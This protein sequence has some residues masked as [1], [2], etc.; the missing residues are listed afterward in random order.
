[1]SDIAREITPVNIEEELKS[2]YLDYA[3]SVIVGRALPDVRDGLKPVHRRVLF[4]MNVLGNDWNKPY[5]K[6]ARVVGDVIGKYHPHGDIAVYGTIVRLAQPF[7]MRYMLVDGQGNFGSVDGDSAAAMRYTEVRMAK[8]AHELLADLEKE[9]VDFVPNYDGTENIPAVMPTRIPNLLVNGSSG[10][11]VGMATNIPPHNLGEVIDGCL[12]YVDNEDI[13]IEELMEYITGP[14]FP[15]AAIINGRRGI[16]D[17]YR[18]GRGKIYIRAQAD[19]ETDEKTGRETIIVTE[20]PYQVNKARLIEKIA[21]LVKDKRIEGISGLRDESDKDG[22]RIV[23][24]IKRDA[25][26][27]VVLNHL[28]SQTQM[29]VSFGINMVALHQGQPKLLNLKEIIAAFIRHRREV[30]TRRTIFELRKAR[31]RAHI[32]EALAVALANIDPV[33]ELIRQAPTPAEAKAALIAQPWDLGSV[34]AMLERAGDSNVARPEWLEPQFGVHDGKY[35]L[36]EQQAQAILDLRLQK[37]TGL[38]HEK[39]LDEYRE[40]LLQIAELLHILRSPERLMDVIRE[41]LTAI[42]TQYNDPRRTEITENTADINIEDLI[43]EE[44]VVVT[45]SHQGYVKY[46]PL[47][48]YEAQR[49]GGKGKSAARIKEEDFIDR[50]LVANTHDTILCFSSRGRLYWMK[51]YQLPEASRG[52]RGRPII[53]LLPLEQDERITAILPVREYEE[54]KFVFMATASGTVKKTPL[55]DFSRPR[56][57]GIIAVNLNDGDELIG[58]DLT[59]GSNEAMLFSADGKVVRFAEECVRPMGRTA[60]GVRGMKL[61]DDDKVVSLIIPRG[62][63]DILTVTENGYGKRTVQSEYPTKN[64]ATQGVISIKVSERNGKVVGAIQVEETDQI[65]MITNA[66]TLVRTRVSEVSIVG[67]NTQ[68]VTLIRTTEDELVVGLQRVEDED[69]ALDDDEVDEMIS[70]N[71]SDVPESEPTDDADSE[72]E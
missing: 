25:V 16:L 65:M 1:M 22:M 45:L 31:D 57:A 46:Q 64:R 15:T 4:A 69:D 52:A 24:E 54:G 12:A 20:I 14:D 38:E 26:G 53:N 19:I 66:G 35:Y 67:R 68:G 3:M 61:V 34:S 63:G 17:A 59:D 72:E 71:I 40:L 70:D 58:V 50:L 28:F 2:S 29:Q 32:L 11:A 37:L 51:V 33:I 5:K 30:V 42:K 60:T 47:T 6:S 36:T 56:S 21:E 8:I 9:T 55:Q 43:N 49:R 13:T 48:D 7:S 62:E 41:E 39:L 27:E 18:T 23:V 10:I 44:N